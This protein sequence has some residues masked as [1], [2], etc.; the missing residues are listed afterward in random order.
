MQKFK[1]GLDHGT[2]FSGQ[3]K[4]FIAA[5]RNVEQRR[6]LHQEKNR[7]ELGNILRSGVLQDSVQNFDE[8]QHIIS[9]ENSAEC[10]LLG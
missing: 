1:I 6:F 4:N 8:F 5:G 3:F 2:L 10:N 9:S 7:G